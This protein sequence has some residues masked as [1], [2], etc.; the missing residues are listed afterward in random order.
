MNVIKILNNYQIVIDGGALQGLE[1]GMKV[2]IYEK[3]KEIEIKDKTISIDKLKTKL[4]IVHIEDEF[5]ILEYPK[6]YFKDIYTPGLSDA[7]LNMDS[8]SSLTG[9][10]K[11]KYFKYTE[12]ERKLF[13]D[14]GNNKIELISNEEIKVGDIAKIN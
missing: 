14:R 13:T 5:S 10:T 4:E 8:L 9:T 7:L 12:E 11:S 1:L 3:G 6:G 2:S